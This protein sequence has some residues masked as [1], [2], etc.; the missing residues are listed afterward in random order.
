MGKARTLSWVQ[1]HDAQSVTRLLVPNQRYILRQ[2]RLLPSACEV[3][4]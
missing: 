2:R 4:S 1:P 3:G